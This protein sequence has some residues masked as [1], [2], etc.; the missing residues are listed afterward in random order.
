M[1]YCLDNPKPEGQAVFIT[2]FGRI[3]LSDEEWKSVEEIMYGN[4][5]SSTARLQR[6]IF[7]DFMYLYSKDEW[8]EG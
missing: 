4:M 8:E 3:Y 5:R 2:P 6:D 1:I 7:R